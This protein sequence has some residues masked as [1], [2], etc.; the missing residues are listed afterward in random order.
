[1]H[2]PLSQSVPETPRRVSWSARALARFFRRQLDRI[3]A[4]IAQGSLSLGLPDGTA[5]LLGGR[6]EG[7]AA[8][9]DL[10]SWRALLR[11]A[12]GGS[13]GWYQAWA[14]GEWASPDP[15]QIFALFGLN[16][17]ALARQA[18]ASGLSRLAKRLLHWRNRNHRGGSRRNIQFHYDL[19]NDFYR[20][21][22][23]P[24]MTYSSALF[25]APG[26]S[27]EQAQHAKLAAILRRTNTKPGDEI[28]EI[29]CGWGSFA[30]LAVAE[31][32]KVHGITLSTEQKAWAETRV[33]ENARFTLT[34]YRD[35]A[36]RYDAIASIEMAEAVGEAYWP[37]YL[38]AI[39]GA[40]KPGGRAALQII[41]FDDAFFDAYAANVDFIQAYVFPGGL[42][43]SESRFATLA[44][45]RG[46]A[47]QDRTGFGLD[48]AETLRLWRERFDA[49]VA[50]G[51]LPAQF[52]RKF[53]DLWRYYL[54][55]CEGGFRGG[56]IDVVQLTLVK[57]AGT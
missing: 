42:L 45:A 15:V 8:V 54:M 32:R 5:R 6:A 17:A 35:V 30:E 33:P 14:L 28:L 34:D 57:E 13:I 48:Y 29:G 40:L 44:A 53:I 1:M 7:P 46:L 43:L 51:T 23:D 39:A 36:G 4:G 55:Y 50:S 56:G 18:R 52:D 16:R 49:A 11:L 19:G 9:V 38:D 12:I 3:D 41:T 37:A 27:L 20:L 26:Q 10:R 31:G 21:W 47:T 25:T 24:G 2:A 22:L